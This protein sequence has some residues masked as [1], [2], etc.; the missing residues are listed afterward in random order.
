MNIRMSSFRLNA[1]DADHSKRFPAHG[2]ADTPVVVCHNMYSH[3]LATTLPAGL[4]FRVTPG[5]V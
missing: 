3:S 5:A 2:P 1:T 4:S